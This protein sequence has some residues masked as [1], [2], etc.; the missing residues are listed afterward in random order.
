MVLSRFDQIVLVILLVG[1][2]VLAGK[3]WLHDHPEHDPG[4]PLS[5]N[6]PEGWATS[7][8]VQAL[9]TDKAACEGFLKR[10]GIA[11]VPLP[12]AGSASCL[13]TDRQVLA[14]PARLEI[15]LSPGGAQATCAV[16]AGLALW[17][18]NEVQ[19]AAEATFGTRVVAVQHLGTANC[20]RIGGG[21]EGNWSEHATGNAIDIAGFVLSDGRRIN[22]RR[23]W[24]GNDTQASA[25]L[26]SVR[27]A[28]CR[29][30]STVLSP[31]YNAAHADHLHLD[32]ARRTGGWGACR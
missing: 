6:E 12:P 23:D 27:D 10:S 14:S 5:L 18:H 30:F 17:L 26:H 31:D 28:A 20:R 21:E 15:A 22:V 1:S 16:D 9:R 2:A 11:A 24:S 19:P 3:A 4:A 8:K 25:F 7:R 13:R 29:S 32:Q